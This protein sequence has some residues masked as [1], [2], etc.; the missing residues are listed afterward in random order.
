MKDRYITVYSE[1]EYR[2]II[3][4]YVQNGYSAFTYEYN[5][6]ALHNENEFIFLTYIEE[7]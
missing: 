5:C 7:V 3:G 1:E 4:V 6:T 2:E